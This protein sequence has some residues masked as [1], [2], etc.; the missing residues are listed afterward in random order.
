MLHFFLCSK[1]VHKY[2]IDAGTGI[3]LQAVTTAA[4][5]SADSLQTLISGH[6]GRMDESVWITEAVGL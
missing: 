6:D 4:V 3:N 5:K 1:A 2:F